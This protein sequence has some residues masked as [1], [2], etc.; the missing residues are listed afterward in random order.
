MYR[1]IDMLY[2]KCIGFSDQAINMVALCSSNKIALNKCMVRIPSTKGGG[3]CR[4]YP[5][6]WHPRSLYLSGGLTSVNM[7][8]VRAGCH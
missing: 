8:L 6:L 3:C 7:A 1:Y 5:L 4:C 2:A